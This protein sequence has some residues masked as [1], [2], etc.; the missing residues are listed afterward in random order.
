MVGLCFF[1]GIQTG[2]YDHYQLG[3][4]IAGSALFYL[5]HIFKSR[6]S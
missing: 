2:D 4:F 1:K 6:L 5:G 3:Q